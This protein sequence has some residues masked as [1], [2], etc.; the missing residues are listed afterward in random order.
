MVIPSDPNLQNVFRRHDVYADDSDRFH[1]ELFNT[2]ETAA[3][4]ML[5]EAGMYDFVNQGDDDANHLL[6]I[7]LGRLGQAI[8]LRV[9]KD[10]QVDSPADCQLKI[11]VIDTAADERR[12]AFAQR[13]PGLLEAAEVNFLHLDIHDPEVT[14]GRYFQRYQGQ[15]GPRGAG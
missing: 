13:Y 10:W 1:L 4:V 7:G 14:K 9:L 8:L 15:A 11:T 3:R 5:R 6:I 12:V 2:Y